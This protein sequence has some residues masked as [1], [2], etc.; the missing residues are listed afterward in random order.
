[1]I[2]T[3]HI[4]IPYCG[5]VAQITHA[6]A[7]EVDIK[8]DRIQGTTSLQVIADFVLSDPDLLTLVDTGAAEYILRVRAPATHHRSVHCS[9]HPQIS[10]TFND[11]Q[12]HG[13]MELWGFLVAVR[14]LPDFCAVGWHDDYDGMRFDIHAGSVLGEDD[15]KEY[16]IDTAE[17]APIGSIFQIQAGDHLAD[18]A[19]ECQLD[20]DRVTVRM[21]SR[22]FQ[23]FEIA[24]NSFDGTPDAAYIMNA[25]YL[26]ALIWVLQEA[27]SSQ[28]EYQDR[29]WYRSLEARLEDC[30]CKGLGSKADDRLVDAQKLLE[31]PFANLPLMRVEP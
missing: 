28:D 2:L 7:F 18:G 5:P 11:G 10:P 9:G 14:D 19:W 20:G 8:P 12:L 6:L 29:R 3:S 1:M 21:S 25:V 27:D 17:E 24:R 16:W 15:P 30:R 4:P 13:R 23:R 22:D 26:P 31:S